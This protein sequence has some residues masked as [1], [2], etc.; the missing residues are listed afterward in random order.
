MPY[1]VP[2][3]QD[4]LLNLEGFRYATALDLNMGYY[5]VRLDADSRKLCTIVLPFGKFEYQRLPQGICNGPDIFQEKMMEL[6]DGMEFIRAYI[7]DL[8]IL[9][10]GDF[11]DHL[12]KLELTLR[13]LM[14]AGLKVNLPKSYFAQ[15]EIEYLGYMITR[16]GIKPQTKKIEAI[17]NIAPPTN[18]RELRR[19]IGIINYYRDMWRG[20]SHYLAPLAAL[21][22]KKQKWKWTPE[23]Q[24]AFDDVKQA[25]SRDVM[26]AYPDFTKPFV[27]HTDASH[28]QLGAVISQ[29]GK[30]IAFYSRKLNSAQ[31]RYTTTERELLSIVETLKEFKNILL[32]HRIVIHTDHKNLTCKNFNTERVM[33]WRL[34]LEE[35]G[36]ELLYIKG[37]DNVVADALSRLPM[38]PTATFDAKYGDEQLMGEFLA[39]DPINP[40]GG[41]PKDFP[42]SYAELAHEQSKDAP[43]QAAVAKSELYGNSD[44]PFADATYNL[45]TR[46]GKIVVPTSMQKRMVDWYH[47]VL[48][49]PGETRMELTI[50]QHFYWSKMRT[51]IQGLCRRCRT[52]RLTKKT[53]VK[54]GKL[55][56]KK[57]DV[58]PWD[59]VCVDLIGPYKFG[60]EHIGQGKK[61][62]PNK[63]FVALHALTMIDPATGWFEIADVAGKQAVEIANAFEIT[64]LSRYPLPTKVTMD[65]GSEFLKDFSDMLRD[66]YGI[67]HKPITSRNPQANSMIERAHKTIHQMIDARQIKDKRDLPEGNWDGML[68][69]VRFAMRSTVH[70]TTQATPTQLVFGRDAILNIGF[71]ANWQYIKSRKQHVILKNNA[72]EN[73]TRR[74]H[75]YKVGDQ[76][77]LLASKTRKHGSDQYLGPYTV[78]AVYDN[79]TV[80]LKRDTLHGGVVYQTWNIRNITPC[81]A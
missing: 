1:P 46:N 13:R 3:I 57:P 81:R 34:V 11:D 37:E 27:I 73:K 22:S 43:L 60:Q 53:T 8:L 47:D 71:E 40:L 29:D 67:V 74:H 45:I 31:T 28:Y 72:R 80:K 49:H 18:V 58:L 2:N 10:K 14:D 20:R 6:F 26:L 38:L 39:N 61:R 42:C 68:S 36:P 15:A 77:M 21:T 23:C 52:C 51:T 50:G 35:F 79:G 55:P 30:P 76:V 9:T 16:E 41:F 59:N 56:P 24:K 4:M 66:D 25:I 75:E 54:Y 33:R 17:A 12:E 48:M 7:D 69:A 62:K 5:H 78:D 70:T 44:F 32:G 65:R 63:D 64:W 19:F